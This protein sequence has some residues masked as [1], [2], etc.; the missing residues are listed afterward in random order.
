M[1]G[2]L[3]FAVGTSATLTET[4]LVDGTPTDLDAGVPTVTI[5]RPDGTT[6]AS[7]TVSNSWTGPPARTTGQYRF[8]LGGQANPTVLDVAWAGVIG[9][10]SQTLHGTVEIV[11]RDL[12]G[13]AE[14]RALKVGGG[15]PFATTATPLFS[16]AQLHDARAATG[17]ELTE[18]LGFSPVPRFA[19]D[20]LDGRGRSSVFVAAHKATGLLSVRIDGTA[21]TLGDFVLADTGQLTWT[22]GTFPATTPGN[23][24][25]E[26]VAGWPRPQGDGGRIAQ[27]MAAAMLLPDGFQTATTASFPDGSTYTYEPSETG[28]GGFVRHTGVRVIDRWLNRWGE[29]RVVVA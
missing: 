10:Q 14:L 12:F 7:G 25:V 5:T 17:D 29:P 21:Q 11:G 1:S 27:L 28:R 23:V 16:D 24:V 3:Q 8:V 4:F 19:R 20:L 15:T 6:I 2:L 18:I 13:L 22:A 26:Y 9:G